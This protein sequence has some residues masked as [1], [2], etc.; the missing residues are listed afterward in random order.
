[1]N[2][3]NLL[4][5]SRKHIK[6][7]WAGD[8]HFLPLKFHNPSSSESVVVHSS[9]CSQARAS[10]LHLRQ[11]WCAGEGRALGLGWGGGGPEASILVCSLAG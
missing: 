2:I 3:T 11:G 10:V 9:L 8:K 1:M 6:R 5:L 4:S 7:L